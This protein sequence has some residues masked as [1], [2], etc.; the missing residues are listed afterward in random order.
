M[1]TF[2][3]FSDFDRSVQCLDKRRAWKQV[4]EADQILDVL[5]G[6]PNKN[7]KPRTGWMNHPAVVMWRGYENAL[8]VYR[9][10]ALQ[11]CLTQHRINTSK[12]LADVGTVVYPA[13]IGSQPFHDSHKSNLLRKDFDFYISKFDGFCDPSLPYIWPVQSG[14]GAAP[15]RSRTI[16]VEEVGAVRQLEKA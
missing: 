10:C 12:V 9:N 5:L 14:K 6:K 4:V 13:W 7:G 15:A 3:P 2:L 16:L 11:V 8:T 1:Q